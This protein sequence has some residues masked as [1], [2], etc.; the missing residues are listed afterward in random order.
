MEFWR[1][2]ADKAGLP[3][4]HLVALAPNAEWDARQYGFDASTP[5]VY[6]SPFGLAQ[7]LRRKIEGQPLLGPVA[8][9]IIRKPLYVHPYRESMAGFIEKNAKWGHYPTVLPN[10]D[11]TPR[12]GRN[13]VVLA[14]STPELFRKHVKE[15]VEMVRNYDE[16]RRI[17]FVKSWNEWAEG[18]HLEPDQKFGHAYMEALRDEIRTPSMT[19]PLPESPTPAPATILG[20]HKT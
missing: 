17:V 10:W 19:V 13:G 16:N 12:S 11:N 5:Q 18:N 9:R 15:A 3:G 1:Q 6:F 7:R 2:L 8:K 20:F 14:G 4:L